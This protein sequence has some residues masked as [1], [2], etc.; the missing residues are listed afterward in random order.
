MSSVSTPRLADVV[1]CDG[2]L[3]TIDREI[4]DLIQDIPLVEAKQGQKQ[5]ID[6]SVK[7]FLHD[8]SKKDYEK[9]KEMA[10]GGNRFSKIYLDEKRRDYDR[11]KKDFIDCLS[12]MVK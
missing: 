6:F 5:C 1:K 11:S 8:R 3:C 2:K 10:D 7:K 9:T 4:F 12:H